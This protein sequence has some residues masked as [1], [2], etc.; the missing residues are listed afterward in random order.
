MTATATE[1]ELVNALTNSPLTAERRRLR[2]LLERID[3]TEPMRRRAIQQAILQAESWWWAWRAEQFHAAA[4]KPGDYNGQAS[5]QE[6]AEASE[7]CVGAARACWSHAHLL[8]ELGVDD[9]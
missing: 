4:P 8:A 7:R 5:A 6:L 2:S 9:D 1:T 3:L